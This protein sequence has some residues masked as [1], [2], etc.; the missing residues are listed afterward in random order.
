MRSHKF[1][2][3]MHYCNDLG[4]NDPGYSLEQDEKTTLL[5]TIQTRV[6]EHG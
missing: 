6:T 3:S 5:K 1:Q 2:N 4:D